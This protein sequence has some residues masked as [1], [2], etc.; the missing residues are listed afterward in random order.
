MIGGYPPVI[1]PG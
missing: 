1:N